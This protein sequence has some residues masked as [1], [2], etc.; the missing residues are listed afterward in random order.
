ML[1]MTRRR[2][3]VEWRHERGPGYD[4]RQY[5]KGKP[6]G[7][8]AATAWHGLGDARPSV[9]EVPG[10]DV[11]LIIERTRITV[12]ERSATGYSGA[13][14]RVPFRSC[15]DAQ[16]LDE[17]G[18]PGASLVRLNLTVR[19]GPD[20][21][22]TV[23]M[24]FDGEHR[25]QLHQLARRIRERPPATVAPPA[26]PPLPVLDVQQAPDTGDWVVFR[27][28]RSSSEVLARGTGETR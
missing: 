11:R 17:P 21:Q 23:P 14:L 16:V 5:Y 2:P 25:P 9:L 10:Q 18:L 27:A 22:L 20:A 24:W 15:V 6:T 7:V 1:R 13:R 12:V 4:L 8:V 26:A 28:H 19:M 3:V